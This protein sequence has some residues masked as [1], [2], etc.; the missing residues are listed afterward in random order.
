MQKINLQGLWEFC[1]DKDKA[2]IKE[3]YYNRS[4][5]DTIT[6]P[7]TVSKEKKGIP[8]D[9]VNIGYLTDPYHFEGYTWYTKE[10][11]FN[12]IKDKELFLI[13]E[14]TRITHVWVDEVYA[15]SNNSLCSSH[16]YDLTS[17]IH[18]SKH[19]ITIM[20]D[21]TSYP[22]K[23]GHMTSPDT[24]TNWNGITGDLYIEIRNKAYIEDVQLYPEGKNNC[25]LVKATLKGANEHNIKVFMSDEEKVFQPKEYELR[26]GNNQFLY[27]A[28]EQ[29]MVW[30][31]HTPK[32]YTLHLDDI[33]ISFGFREFRAAGSYFEINGTRTFLRGKHDGLIFPMTGYALTDVDSWLNV[34]KTAKDYGINHY[35]FHTCTPPKAAFTAADMLGVYM[36]PELPFWGTVTNKGEENHDEAAQQYLI[37]EGF[38]IL[39]EFGNHPSFVMMSLG[40][41][42]WGSKERLNEILGM[43][44]AYDNRHLYTQGSNNF[45]FMPCILENEDFYCGVR[46]SKDRLFRGSYAM[47]DAPLGHIQTLPPNTVS[48]YDAIIRPNQISREEA[49]GGEITIQYG[50]GT[51]IV[52]MDASEEIIPFIPVVS[53]EI[54]QYAMYPDYTEIDKYTGVLKAR[55]LEVF[56]ERL[57]KQNMLF[58]AD[59]FFKASGRFAAQCYKAEIETALRSNEL[60]GFQVLDLQ[61][62]TGQGTA[63]VGILNSFMENKGV[64]TQDEWSQFCSDTVLLLELSK[65]IFNSG[66]ELSTG[67]KLAVYS[68]ISIINPVLILS[69]WDGDKEIVKE[70]KALTG[71]YANGLF[72]LCNI[73]FN[74][75]HLTK[76]KNLTITVRLKSTNISN[77]YQIWVY[78]DVSNKY[79]RD[80]YIREKYTGEGYIGEGYIKGLYESTELILTSDREK[81]YE[82]LLKGGKVLYFPDNLDETNSVEGTYCTDFWCYPMFRSISESVGKPVPVGT[83]GLFIDKKHPIFKYFPTDCYSTPQW[84]DFVSNSRA[85]ILDNTNI[86]PIVWTIDNFERNHRLGNIFEICAGNG[87]LLICTA[88][89]PKIENSAPAKWLEY[90]ILKYLITPD[91]KPNKEMTLKELKHMLK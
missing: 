39:K 53:H 9:E 35:R 1:L 59:M 4:F 76:P 49:E 72:D 51:K 13:I 64:I 46:F 90:S 62:F 5:N 23:G 77:S 48:N 71:F 80:G 85:L 65:H 61:D 3:K 82:S 25:I 45:Q 86:E 36:E 50:T 73:T 74:L 38:R 26:E 78:P 69:V 42:L 21:N 17:F 55:N 29:V 56:K 20:V 60:A 19:K 11:E 8:S 54:G 12:D 43:Y 27:Q 89:L 66:E 2:G 41:E 75:P 34:L 30:S 32:L 52:Q 44:K 67:I 24:Q 83:H 18:E 22:V 7:A 16:R 81:V 91:F 63:L 70:E 15:G 88:N 84:Y 14:R 31:E 10:V 58:M 68:E 40:N 37:D 28:E 33:C 57:T 6:L 87:K 47:C 79:I